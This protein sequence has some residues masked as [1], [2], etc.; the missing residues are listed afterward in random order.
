M[1]IV[2]KFNNQRLNGKGLVA[3]VDSTEDCGYAM[4][5]ILDN[6]K[7]VDATGC[8]KVKGKEL[9]NS[10]CDVDMNEEVGALSYHDIQKQFMNS[11]KIRVEISIHTEN[12]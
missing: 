12:K 2:V 1:N 11:D 6:A 4:F 7:L 5:E 9:A 8:I 3:I 10:Y